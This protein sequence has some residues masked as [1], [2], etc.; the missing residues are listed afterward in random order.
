MLVNKKIAREIARTS[1]IKSGAD[2]DAAR[3]VAKEEIIARFG[4]VTYLIVFYYIIALCEKLWRIWKEA[5]Y[6]IPPNEPV[7]GE[8]E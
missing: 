2:I 6:L 7:P 1:Y 4:F 5:N 3:G 8:P